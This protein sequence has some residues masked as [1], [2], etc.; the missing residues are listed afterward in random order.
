MSKT[1]KTKNTIAGLRAA[2]DR[3]VRIPN[4]IKAGIAALKASGEEF[5][6]E[7]DFCQLARISLNEIAQYR[8]QFKGFWGETPRE[9]GKSHAKK[10]WFPSEAARINCGDFIT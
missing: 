6:Y 10:V 4:A 2:H 1:A 3:K 7:A 5:L 8:D 9:G